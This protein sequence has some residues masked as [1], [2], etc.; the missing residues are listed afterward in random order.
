MIE[1]IKEYDTQFQLEYFLIVGNKLKGHLNFI[2]LKSYQMEC[3]Y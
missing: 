3:I 1:E 2:T